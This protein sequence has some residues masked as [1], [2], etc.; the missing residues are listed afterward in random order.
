MV[1]FSIHHSKISPGPEAYK[2]MNNRIK[3]IDLAS[4]SLHRVLCWWNIERVWLLPIA[5]CCAETEHHCVVRSDICVGSD[6]KQA[7]WGSQNSLLRK[8]SPN[9]MF[10]YTHFVHHNTWHYEWGYIIIRWEFCSMS[11]KYDT[12]TNVHSSCI[13]KW[14]RAWYVVWSDIIFTCLQVDWRNMSDPCVNMLLYQTET[15]L[16][17]LLQ[18][19]L[20]YSHVTLILYHSDI[21]LRL[22][23]GQNDLKYQTKIAT[24]SKFY[25]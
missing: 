6:R 13:D 5:K 3:Q 12:F 17:L 1:S 24:T 16:S 25:W 22:Q 23:Q 8:L 14:T 21:R 20:G 19:W 9:T 11:T 10:P 7:W 15:Y 18:I 4:K 2:K